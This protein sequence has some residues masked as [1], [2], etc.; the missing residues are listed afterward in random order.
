ML[1][2]LWIDSIIAD[3]C[4]NWGTFGTHSQSSRLLYRTLGTHSC[5]S[6]LPLNLFYRMYRSM[7][8]SGIERLVDSRSLIFL[9]STAKHFQNL[10]VSSALVLATVC[11]SGLRATWRILWLWPGMWA[12]RVRE[13]VSVPL[14]EPGLQMVRWLSGWPWEERSSLWCEDH[15]RPLT[16]REGRSWLSNLAS[17][18]VLIP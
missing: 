11:P 16:C 4:A 17:V 7:L 13:G 18:Q 15:R 8:D 6:H 10:N 9:E 12:T 3:G 2:V 14:V 1:D 5:I